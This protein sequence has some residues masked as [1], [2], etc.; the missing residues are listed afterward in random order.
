LSI[1]RSLR[2]T[3]LRLRDITNLVRYGPTA[4]QYAERI[5][6]KPAEI[7]HALVGPAHYATCSGKVI[8]VYDNF[9]LT[10]LRTTPRIESCVAHWVHGVPWEMTR[11]Y[12]VMLDAIRRGDD[13]AGCKTEEDLRRRFQALDKMFHQ[14]RACGRLKTRQE[15]DSGV[16]RE[17]GGV[18]VCIGAASEPLL[19]DGFHRLAAALILNLPLIPAQ[20]GYVDERALN[21]LGRYRTLPARDQGVPVRSESG[22]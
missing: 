12:R 6:V 22:D 17:E 14:T 11:D 10:D 5:W 4:P 8:R 19:Y 15:L 2:R 20:L 21:S 7:R 9:R 3:V 16:F 13:W 1:K 18:L